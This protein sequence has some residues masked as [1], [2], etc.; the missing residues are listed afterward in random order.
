ML[1]TYEEF[2]NERR[3]SDGMTSLDKAVAHH[4]VSKKMASVPVRIAKQLIRFR[5]R[6]EDIKK[7]IQ[8][9]ETPRERAK[10][11]KQ[12]MLVD[13]KEFEAIKKAKAAKAK[14]KRKEK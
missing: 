11:K 7:M 6:K 2:L 8:Q 5:K 4:A 13:D 14:L 10:L 9:A 12:L 1:K 3:R